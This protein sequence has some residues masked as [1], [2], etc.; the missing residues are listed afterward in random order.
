MKKRVIFLALTSAMIIMLCGSVSAADPP[1]ADFSANVT[2]GTAPLNVQF[3]DTST[4]NATSWAWDFDNDGTTDSNH[5]NP[6]YTYNTPGNYS[7]KLTAGNEAGN[8]TLTK[9]NYINVVNLLPSN[10]HIF[11]NVSND[12]GVKYNTDGTVHGGPNGTYYIKA[13]GGGMNELHITNNAT[14]PYGQITA[15][16]AINQSSSG[17]FYLTNT[18]G[19]GYSDDMILMISVQGPIPDDFTLHITS[20]GYNWT[21]IGSK[22]TEYQY[23]VGA[24]N[25]TFTKADFMYGPHIYK[26][27][28]GTLGVWSLPLYGG[29]NTNDPSTAQYLMFVDLYAGILTDSSLIDGGSVKVEFNFTNMNTFAAFNMYG[30]SYAATQ[31]Q[32]ISWTQNPTSSGYYIDYI[33]P[34]ANFTATPTNGKTPLTVEFTDTSSGNIINAWAWDFDNDGTI[35]STE[36]NPTYTYNNPGIYTVKLTV[37]GPYDSASEIKTD[38][39]TITPVT[40]TRTNK[41]YVNIQSA[42]DDSETLDGD[43]I[44][45]GS[46]P[47]AE[48]YSENVNVTKQL[49]IATRGKVTVTAL[50]VNNPVFKIYIGGTNS[51]IN[52]FIITG[53]T[54]SSGI[55]IDPFVNAT[56]VGNNITSN[57][58]GIYVGDGNVT[59]IGNN[60]TG[61]SNN[62]VLIK[63]GN[64]I[65]AENNITGNLNGIYIEDSDDTTVS[66][67]NN[68]TENNITDNSNVGIYVG[69]GSP[70]IHYNRICN[71]GLYGLEDTAK[72]E[73]TSNAIFNWWGNNTPMY[74]G[75]TSAP[76]KSDIYDAHESS[77]VTYDP[78]IVLTVNATSDLLKTGAKSNITADLTHDNNGNAVAGGQI[79]DSGQIVFAYAL[80]TV[81]PVNTTLL[82]NTA[83]ATVTGGSTSGIANITATIDEYTAGIPITMDTIA[84]IVS[85]DVLGGTYNNTQTVTLTTNDPTSTIYY[86]INGTKPT[87]SSTP[88]TGPITINSTAS[89]K[90]AALDPASNWSPV[91]IQN[92]LIGTTPIA[93]SDWPKFQNDINN[94]GLSGYIGPQ[95]NNTAWIYTTSSNIRYAAPVIGTDGTIYIGNSARIF[96]AINPDGTLKWSYTS[97]GAI[98]G[99]ATIG[100]DGTI[101]FCEEYAVNALYSNGTRKWQYYQGQSLYGSPTIGSDG[102]IYVGCAGNK[103]IAINPDGTLKWTYTT[104]S[105]IYYSSPAIGTDGTIYIGSRDR[106]VYAINPDGTLKWKFRTGGEI[107][108]SP[109]IGPD[110]TIYI[111]SYDRTFYAIN[112]DGTLKWDYLTSDQNL[113]AHA[114]YGSAAIGADGTIYIGNGGGNLFALNPD[115]TLKWRYATGGSIQGSPVIDA[116]GTIYFGS[117]K[118]VY[119]LNPDGTLKWNYTTGN[120]IQGSP[121][122]GANETLYIGSYDKKLYAFKDPDADLNTSVTVNNP[123]LNIGDDLNID[124]N[125]TNNGSG[126]AFRTILTYTLPA[127]LKYIDVSADMGIVSYNASNRMITWNIGDF[128]VT[129]SATMTILTKVIA[130]GTYT[131]IPSLTT[132][133]SDPNLTAHTGSADVT[134]SGNVVNIRTGTTYNT[135]QE[136]IDDVSTLDGDTINVGIGNYTENVI[137]NKQLILNA[138]GSATVMALN[139]NNPVFSITIAGNNSVISGFTITGAIN[140]YGVYIAT[141]VNSTIANN[142]IIENGLEG[143]FIDGNSNTTNLNLNT[144]T[145]NTI[146]N[147]ERDGIRV[148][149][150]S[151]T[152]NSNNIYS[153]ERDG[154]RIQSGNPTINSNN[155]YSNEINGIRVQAGNPI[156]H[157]NRIYNNGLYGLYDVSTTPNVTNATYNWWGTNNPTYV[158]GTSM[159]GKSDIY[160]AHTS[161]HVVYN[162]WIVL[163]ANSIPDLL[164]AGANATITAY[165]THDSNGNVITGQV[166]DGI[167]VSFSTDSGKINPENKTTGGSATSTLT[168]GNVSGTTN[169]SVTVDAC[170]VSVP[171]TVDTVAPTVTNNV[172]G[173]TYNSTQNV[174]LTVDEPGTIYYTTNGTNPT[175]SSNVFQNPIVINT[176]TTLRYAAVDHAGNWSPIYLINYVIG[177]GG[178]ADTPQPEFQNNNN[179]TGQSD[180]SG[181]Q[182]NTTF[183]N[184]NTGTGI[185]GYGSP[186][187]GAD[188]TI[189]VGNSA[190][191]L[192]AI[193]SNGTLKWNYTT[194]SGSIQSAP[195][196]GAD[197]TIYFISGKIIYALNSNGTQKWNYTMG[198]STYASPAISADGTIYIGSSDKNL[199]SINPDGTLKW[200]YLTEPGTYSSGFSYSTPAIGADGTIY[201]GSEN[202]RFYAINPDGT[203]KWKYKVGGNI[204]SSPSIGAD[205]TIYF[206]ANNLFAMNPDGTLKW[207]YDTPLDS[208]TSTSWSTPAIGT[209]GTIYFAQSYSVGALNSDG[210]LK[211]AYYTNRCMYYTSA[212]IGADG[213]IYFGCE[214][215]IFAFNP[216]GTQKW[217]RTGSTYAS[218]IGSDG[219]LYF[220]SQDGNLYAIKDPVPVANFTA[221]PVNGNSPLTVQFNDTSSYAASWAWDFNNDGVVDSTEQNPTHT[222]SSTGRYAVKLTVTNAAGSVSEIKTDYITV[223]NVAPVPSAN[224][225]SGSYN[226]DLTVNLTAVDDLDSN[227]QIYYTLDGSD[228]TTSSIL[229]T[230]PI[231]INSAGTTTLKFIA[232]DATGNWSP[233]Y[234]QTYTIDITTSTVT[235]NPVGGLFNTTQT[236]TLTTNEPATIYYTT[237]GSTPT[238]TS[239]QYTT[240]IN[241]N[242]TTT[243][244]FMAIDAAGNQGTVQTETYNIDTTP[245][246]IQT[247]PTGGNYNITQTITLTTNEPATIYYT[248]DGTTPTTTSNQYTTPININTTTTL[249]FIAI[250]T[251]GNQGTVQTETYNIDTTPPTIQTNPTGGNYNTAQTITLTPNET[252]TIYYTTDGSTPTNHSTQYTGPI[253]ISTTTT[254]KFMAIDAAGNQGTVQ[255]ET[256]NIKSDV[257]VQI[258]PSITNPTVGDKVTYTF[259]LGN[260]GPG[261]ASNIVFTYV[262]PEGVE[263]AGANVDQGTVNYDPTTRT[264]T[265]TVG[266]VAAG[267]DP[268]LWL[269]LNI[270]NAGTFNIQPTVTVAGYNPELT[271]NIESLLINA[272]IAPTTNTE[273]TN[274]ANAA[275]TTSIQTGTIPMQTTGIP[276]AGL[277]LGILCIGSGITLSRKK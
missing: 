129:D 176:T 12:E 178:L 237:D 273:N 154:I 36:Q 35:D 205:G 207:I 123:T 2:N 50:D 115:G 254:L 203:L 220:G 34:V 98:Y 265:W 128:A 89:L 193:N 109:V 41:T 148:L 170:T 253:N 158:M 216:D 189:Y 60:I 88:Y 143:I 161:A 78:W 214:S 147:N 233:V 188:G 261:D 198:S 80:G 127:W 94:T 268:Y 130:S 102:T 227:P 49:T 250:D 51:I 206:T 184:Y 58:N 63:N 153:N 144:I 239:N 5:Q 93:D 43:T 171:V 157:F 4:N 210:T 249:K 84:P 106:Y 167:P 136:A 186:T 133:T 177:P 113:N 37:S 236:I 126:T 262:I 145:G 200:T 85:A 131:I 114:I 179:H 20:Y 76:G 32:G 22:P 255:T 119:A 74:V 155:I 217:N 121:A 28:P 46:G 151:P 152:I 263:Y 251:F 87:T 107:D 199:Y 182:T 86:T 81:T 95:T 137:V 13:D 47:Y 221:A 257:Y 52:G 264:L 240:P 116:D 195:A 142:T 70:N 258:T 242:T 244:K 169:A 71:N 59:I 25:Q 38:F 159:P 202:G 104:G 39:I 150:G 139:V 260:N 77:H 228:P 164:K 235:A 218:T 141:L 83:K 172:P 30:W 213:T 162:P 138:L 44:L 175:T 17:V 229:Y 40:N 1:V 117:N 230:E 160:D 24:V 48:N 149:S 201:I 231:N 124:F 241:I 256:Y 163:T 18:G 99:S 166:P 246:T 90:F 57:L 21:P 248:T 197:G 135:I 31:G 252:A 272:A 269:N 192:F 79:P 15:V 82:N 173:G 212:A 245:P 110:G 247:N 65:I 226:T 16:T 91:N 103:L 69:S 111:G 215:N 191:V 132:I 223:D 73:N 204:R 168:S 19:R 224:L 14:I 61:N 101:Y 108:G 6:T 276:I 259:K 122:I 11:I 225:P 140:S 275:T 174:N 68:I 26:P 97:G 208:R 67:R 274:T 219:A 56:I 100:G 165:L 277:I 8:N 53:A 209:D 156:I 180:Y 10:R 181:P 23:L 134:V 211:W 7:V 238:T 33:P 222:Y 267:V 105:S 270:L 75:R 120:G 234:N 62:G 64:A 3:T 196:I 54:N 112:P 92:Y 232:V 271:N 243:L 29:Q 27:G 45:V 266:N 55:Y 42:I 187:I 9:F 183:W 125:V 96:Y 66:V 72:G 146:R 190:G 194:G 185:W 118:N